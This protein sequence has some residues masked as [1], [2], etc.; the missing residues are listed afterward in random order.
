VEAVIA[1]V[2]PEAEAKGLK[3]LVRVAPDVPAALVGDPLRLGQILLNLAG[4][5][6]KFTERGTVELRVDV[7]ARREASVA[8]RFAVSDTGIGLTEEQI[9]RLFHAFSQADGSTTRKFGG[10][11]LGLAFSQRL[12]ELMGGRI[13][14]DSHPG[15]GTTF[16]VLVELVVDHAADAR[17]ERAP[18]ETGPRDERRLVGARVLLVEDNPMNRQL[19]EELLQQEGAECALAINGWLAIETLER[20]GIDHFD[21]VLIDLQMPEMDG[22]EAT[23][24][25]RMMEGAQRLPLIALTAHAMREERE[26]CL[27]V[28]M[29]D[30][31]AKPVDPE[32]LTTKLI[33]WIGPERLAAARRRVPTET[34]PRAGRAVPSATPSGPD[35]PGI[36]LA[37]GLHRCGGDRRLFNELLHQ[38]DVLYADAARELQEH[39][40]AGRLKEARVLVHSV[41]GTA[42]SLGMEELAEAAAE[43]EEALTQAAA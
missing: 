40:A 6:V 33:E 7:E 13:W 9:A 3:M 1:Q 23:R 24:R 34:G 20:L 41:R 35:L 4:N 22:Y 39:C 2:A 43:L 27:A 28:G 5:A 17:R 25:I 32:L 15:V 30:H 10:T 38:F 42:A 12:V 37:A 31:L 19:T 16:Y 18:A 14:V 29:Q 26:R 36:D 8:L 21:A 11:G